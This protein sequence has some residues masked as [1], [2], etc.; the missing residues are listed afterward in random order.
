V[1]ERPGQDLLLHNHEERCDRQGARRNRE[2]EPRRVA[3]PD[4][5]GRKMGVGGQGRD[6]TV[7]RRRFFP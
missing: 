3:S 1:L 4:L 5:P 6:P 2:E 7:G